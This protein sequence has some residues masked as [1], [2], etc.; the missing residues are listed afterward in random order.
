[1][2]CEWT[3]DTDV[4]VME[5]PQNRTSQDSVPC[6]IKQMMLEMESA[7]L[8]DL[9]INGHTCERSTGVAGHS[10]AALA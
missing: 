10:I 8:V 3:S 2:T 4:V 7:G 6:T 1:M 9:T 5:V